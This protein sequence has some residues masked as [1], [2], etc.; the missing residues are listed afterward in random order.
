MQWIDDISRGA[1]RL[2]NALKPENIKKALSAEKER[3]KNLDA[4]GWIEEGFLLTSVGLLIGIV[5]FCFTQSPYY[6]EGTSADPAQES[7]VDTGIPEDYEAPEPGTVTDFDEFYVDESCLRASADNRPT[8][9]SLKAMMPEAIGVYLDD[10]TQV[11]YLDV[12]WE[13]VELDYDSTDDFY[14]QFSPQWDTETY[15]LDSTLDPVA[16]APYIA[17]FLETREDGDDSILVGLDATADSESTDDELYYSEDGSIVDSDG[18]EYAWDE[19]DENEVSVSDTVT[20]TE[21]EM[22]LFDYLVNDMGLNTAAACGILACAH[23]NSA[24]RA[25][26]LEDSFEVSLGM[27]D[28]TYTDAVDDGTYM[29]FGNDGA[30]YG[31]FR[32]S[33]ADH[34]EGL[35]S[36]AEESGE[37]VGDWLVQLGYLE[38]EL[39]ETYSNVWNYLV[40]V[41]NTAEGAYNAAYFWCNYYEKAEGAS[42]LAITRGNLARDIYWSNYSWYDTEDDYDDYYDD[43]YDDEDSYEDEMSGEDYEYEYEDEDEDSDS[44]KSSS[45]ST[46][47][48]TS[49]TTSRATVRATTQPSTYVSYNSTTRSSTASTTSS[50]VLATSVTLNATEKTLEKGGT[51]T[52]KATLSPSNATDTMF[53]YTGNSSVATVSS[54]KVTAVGTGS[55]AITVRTSGGKM[56]S[57][58]FTVIG[59]VTAPQITVSNEEPYVGDSVKISWDDQDAATGYKIY[60]THD[61]QTV[62]ADTTYN[63]YTFKP[64]QSGKYTIKVRAYNDS[65]K[66]TSSTTIHVLI[67]A[68]EVS[69]S[70]SKAVLSAGKTLKLTAELGP[71]GCTGDSV[72]S[73]ESSNDWVASVSSKGKITAIAAGSCTI[74]VTTKNGLTDKC[75]V[76]VVDLPVITV[77]P[78]SLQVSARDSA[79]FYVDA[80]GTDLT[81]QWQYRT[82]DASPWSNCTAG[83]AASSC[84]TVT[85]AASLNGTSYRCVIT[86]TAGD[87]VISDAAVL[88]VGYDTPVILTQPDMAVVSEGSSA[89]F[90]IEAIG[91]DLTFLWQYREDAD[92]DWIDT[93]SE[94]PEEEP[95]SSEAAEESTE[96]TSTE[97]AESTSISEETESTAESTSIS[98][99][100]ESTAENTSEEMTSSAALSLEEDA[101]RVDALDQKEFS[102]T[103]TVTADAS[104]DGRTYRCIVTDKNGQSITSAEAV[105]MIGSGITISKQPADCTASIGDQIS[106]TVKAASDDDSTITYQ[107]QYRAAG[108]TAWINDTAS[109]AAKKTLKVKVKAY[110][111]G[112]RYRCVLTN[113]DGCVLSTQSAELTVEE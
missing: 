93:V 50:R 10:D 105:L 71:E 66:K 82:T 74:T 107:W 39:D 33:L 77:Q 91:E 80:E 29:N 34:K 87:S 111:N 55:T 36:Y 96:D 51:F 26:N 76:T 2:V 44:T 12:T 110:M 4:Q 81:Y 48:A 5:V 83:D 25:N 102:D 9:E 58:K 84:M 94:E 99:E 6:K 98:E 38:T 30:G 40:S 101:K 106:F 103:L 79:L 3:L 24:F 20:G 23:P 95:E 67:K 14:Y 35:L 54:G 41:P 32:W 92:S 28:E 78:E 56:A 43:S 17:V 69:L 104:I 72:S 53:W 97:E 73:W 59:K 61:D 68:T 27:D 63:T 46:S 31:L 62:T 52:L 47:R 60:V 90:Y 19:E 18:Y 88:T 15:P 113:E 100:S 13:C 89:S 21:E 70:E 112:R 57:C 64:T 85:A 42:T 108:G 1:D 37:S 75:K 49:S 86:N 11:S 109:T 8:E 16:D 22:N 65:Y 45:S 7:V